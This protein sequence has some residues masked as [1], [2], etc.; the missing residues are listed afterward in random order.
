VIGAIHTDTRFHKVLKTCSSLSIRLYKNCPVGCSHCCISAMP[1]KTIQTGT[2]QELTALISE[3]SEMATLKRVT[4]TGPEIV[5]N[6]PLLVSLGNFVSLSLGL[7]AGVLTSG[8]WATSDVI[9]HKYIRYLRE[10]SVSIIQISY[11]SYHPLSRKVE[12]EPLVQLL[13]K[14]GFY[15]CVLETIEEGETPKW[16]SN[17]L[18]CDSYSYQYV[19]NIG[20]HNAV[21]N[22][23]TSTKDIPTNG[24]DFGT[25]VYVENDRN[26]YLCSGAGCKVESRS[27]GKI[28]PEGRIKWQSENW[29]NLIALYPAKGPLKYFEYDSDFVKTVPKS[30]NPC[31]ACWA[32][33]TKSNLQPI[34]F[35]QPNRE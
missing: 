28:L 14:E 25:R 18:N 8:F 23:C 33:F 32:H 30:M 3:I 7:P 20:R 16:P 6:D 34:S 19:A 17:N 35:A 13:M 15:V 26:I 12:I 24:C 31:T 5:L 9:I 4:F 29:H 21:K 11:D 10:A 1:G 2:N 22:F 27:I